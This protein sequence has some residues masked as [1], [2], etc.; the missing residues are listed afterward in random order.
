MKK[1]I[2]LKDI[3]LK[4]NMSISTVSKSLLNNNSISIL[5][6]ERVKDLAK[7]WGYVANE[8]ARHFKLNKSFTIGL[9]L[10]D[11]LDQ[12]FVEAINGVEEI[13]TKENYN[14]ILA[15]SHED[16]EKEEKIVNIM[17][18][19]RVDGL[20]VAVTKNTVDMALFQK[21]KLV[22]IPVIFIVRE[23]QNHSFSYVSV[24]N[25]EGAFKATDFLIKKGHHRIAH[26]MAPKTM[27]ISLVRLEGY[28]QALKKSMISLDMDLVKE[29]DFTKGETEK[30]MLELMEMKSPPTAIFTFKNYIT[31]D[32][33][34]FLKKRFPDRLNSI[35][36]TDFGNLP[37]FDYLDTK[38]I[39]SIEENFY[40]V[41][42]QATLLLF[43]MINEENESHNK[44]TKHIEIPCKLVIHN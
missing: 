41:G 24:N 26:L 22:A 43:Q 15:Q 10:P 27:H 7:E 29:V 3:A 21:F 11:L 8:S 30:A 13:A 42:K 5:T 34:R 44:D 40:E 4:L 9:I 17:I 2:T 18:K 1:G 12:F 38:P 25:I 39:A 31:L 16:L 6:R 28:K 35:D 32:A 20:I 37:L 36:F 23:P 33:I 14:I 19:N